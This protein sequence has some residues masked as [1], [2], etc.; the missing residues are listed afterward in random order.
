MRDGFF[1]K[2][3]DDFG[4]KLINF[5]QNAVLTNGEQLF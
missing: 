3:T 4:N 2:T 5:Y 1:K